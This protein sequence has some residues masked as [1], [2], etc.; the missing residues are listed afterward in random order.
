MSSR[1][2]RRASDQGPRSGLRQSRPLETFATVAPP[3][4][5]D[6]C[7]SGKENGDNAKLF[8]FERF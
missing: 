8:H 4:L 1:I 2:G 5:C 7:A 6:R 3:A